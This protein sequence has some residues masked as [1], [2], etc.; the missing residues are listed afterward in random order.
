[1]EGEQ[2]CLGGGGQ[3]GSGRQGH[4]P[5]DPSTAAAAPRPGGGCRGHA[6]DAVDA[7]VY[8][9][10]VRALTVPITY[11]TAFSKSGRSSSPT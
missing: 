5:P 3:P 4:G 1:V 2:V 9:S 6:G 7:S 11:E 10:D 8:G